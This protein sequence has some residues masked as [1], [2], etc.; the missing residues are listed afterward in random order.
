M[1]SYGYEYVRILIAVQSLKGQVLYCSCYILYQVS[2]KK[3]LYCTLLVLAI[4]N[5]SGLQLNHVEIDNSSLVV[6]YD[7]AC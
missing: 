4:A 6:V 3:L 1:Y 2:G 7:E 5:V